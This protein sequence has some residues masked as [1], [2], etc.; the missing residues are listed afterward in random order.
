MKKNLYFLSFLFSIVYSTIGFSQSITSPS[1]SYSLPTVYTNGSPNDVIYGFCT[2]NAA[3]AAVTGS[4]TATAGVANCTF[5]WTI[6]DPTT[7]TYNPFTTQ[8]G[9]TTSTLT[10]L[11]SGGYHVTIKNSGGTVLFCDLAWVWVNQTTAT[12]GAIAAGCSPF[13]LN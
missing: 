9:L 10:G 13:N 12:V 2:P 4:L 7:N 5:I 8:T 6:F 3:G 11:A 1:A